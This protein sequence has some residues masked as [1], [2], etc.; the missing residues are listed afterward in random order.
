[1]VTS[2]QCYANKAVAVKL[3]TAVLFPYL[4]DGRKILLDFSTFIYG[5]YFLRVRARP[6]RHPGVSRRIS[7]RNCEVAALGR[8]IRDDG[9]NEQAAHGMKAL[10][11][12][13]SS[14]IYDCF[15]FFV[16]VSRPIK[17]CGRSIVGASWVVHSSAASLF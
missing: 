15:F 13:N 14:E 17:F 16:E 12:N 11:R 10:V 3:T 7:T 1:M 8:N 5:P 9:E 6:G 2:K 4:Y